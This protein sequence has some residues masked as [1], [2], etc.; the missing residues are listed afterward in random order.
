MPIT[1]RINNFR[2]SIDDERSLETLLAVHF[3]LPL[4]QQRQLK[5]LRK[6]LDARRDD[7]ISF[8]YTLEITMTEVADKWTARWGSDKNIT[9]VP[10]ESEEEL[11]KGSCPLLER[12]V[13]IGFGPSGMLAALTLAKNGYRPLVLER[14]ADVERR[15]IAVQRFWNE[16]I[17]DENSNVQ[18]GEGG[19]GTFSDGK[20][21][22]RVHDRLMGQVLD[23][24]IEAG[25]PPEIKYW[26]K[27]HI[28]TDRLRQVVKNIRGQIENAGGEVR[29]RQ[30]VTDIEVAS[31]KLV[32]VVVN[33][34]T[35]IPCS[36]ALFG[37]GHSA[38]DTYQMLYDRGVAMEAKA[39][40]IGVRIEHPQELIDRS[41]YGRAVGHPKLGSADY[42]LVYHDKTTDRTAYSF[43]MC[44]GGM[45]I[46]AAS[47]NGGVVVNGMS[48]YNRG[49][50]AANS[51][52]AVNVNPADYGGGVLDGIKFQREYERKAFELAGSSWYA[53]VQSVG[54]FLTGKS[55][56]RD[57]LVRP[58]YAPGTKSVNLD[59]CLPEFVTGTLRRALPDFGR[60]IKGFDNPAAVMTGVETRTSSPLRILR[61]ADRISP[62]VAGFYPMG[63][64]AGYAGG[65]MS[66]ALDGM[67]TALAVM[68]EYSA[69]Y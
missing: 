37:I 9:L 54:G 10:P 44:P 29:F 13:I 21:T 66:A 23:A 15:Q 41:Q 36:L 57:F 40:A 31:G 18:F 32:G 6:A 20:L 49:S 59:D 2:V 5:I 53:P 8:V 48:H 52:L 63:E 56:G 67:N 11:Q 39:F 14:G 35:V 28:G 1:L 33:G 65:I 25:A 47:E 60:K 43:C 19:A 69:D 26:Y 4:Q 46:G 50:G 58:S 61:G 16:G 24:L 7:R 45:V 42:A 55:G 12:P 68:R 64:G 17:L 30:Q 51:A 22:T 34:G 3:Q 62:T 38:R 27:P